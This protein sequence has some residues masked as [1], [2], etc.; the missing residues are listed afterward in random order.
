MEKG[1][2]ISEENSSG[3]KKY[4]VA[5]K[6]D[7]NA[8]DNDGNTA[9]MLA[10]KA[11]H[12]KVVAYLL[13]QN[14]IDPDIKNN[15]RQSV[16]DIVDETKNTELC[17]MLNK[18]RLKKQPSKFSRE[19]I[20][21]HIETMRQNRGLQKETTSVETQKQNQPLSAEYVIQKSKGYYKNWL[22]CRLNSFGFVGTVQGFIPQSSASANVSLS[23]PSVALFLSS[24][25]RGEGDA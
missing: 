10:A 20:G 4:T 12:A 24:P 13:E 5:K 21:R 15:N 11:G 1:L 19:E 3:R 14:T 2:Q 22:F 16:F 7:L 25:L 8:R 18:I 23:Y 17:E 9:L 6:I